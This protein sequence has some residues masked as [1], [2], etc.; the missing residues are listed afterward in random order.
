MNEIPHDCKGIS[1]DRVGDWLDDTT[2]HKANGEELLYNIRDKL[3]S[4]P[5]GIYTIEDPFAKGREAAVTIEAVG[6][7]MFS[8]VVRRLTDLSIAK[9][10]RL[11]EIEWWNMKGDFM[12]YGA[13]NLGG[14]VV[15]LADDQEVQAHFERALTYSENAAEAYQRKLDESLR[16]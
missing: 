15:G 3:S 10:A 12:Q 4:V 5:N 7:G 13:S 16:S 11:P 2:D 6:D 9:E 1:D 8:I 14:S